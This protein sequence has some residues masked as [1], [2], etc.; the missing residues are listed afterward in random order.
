MEILLSILSKSDNGERE[1]QCAVGQGLVI[2]RGAEDG[3]LL[4]GEDLSREH[5]VL[6][7]D[8]KFI[9]ATDL[10]VNGTWVNGKRLKKSVKSRVHPNDSIEV[11]GYAITFRF[12][13]QAQTP[14]PKSPEASSLLPQAMNEEDVGSQKQGPLAALRPVYQFVASF[15][16]MEKIM[17]LVA[18]CGL[19]LL[20][21]YATS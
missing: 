13:E 5:L 10:S 9:F 12:V 6:T 14:G 15:T 17:F 16:A 4:E 2:G 8:G 21:T 1:L 11:P 7:D 19:T 18:V 3:I 20:Y